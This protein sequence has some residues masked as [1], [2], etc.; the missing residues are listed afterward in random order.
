MESTWESTHCS[1]AH[2]GDYQVPGSQGR[3]GSNA[4]MPQ[5]LSV[6]SQSTREQNGTG[7]M[8]G[9]A[10]RTGL[11]GVVDRFLSR[12]LAVGLFVDAIMGIR[13]YQ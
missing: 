2:V 13:G 7:L 8:D 5:S 12:Y 10:L 1:S 6:S 11:P 4:E 9:L 3:R